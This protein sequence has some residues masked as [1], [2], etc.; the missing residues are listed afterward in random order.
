MSGQISR[1]VRYS[2]LPLAL[3]HLLSLSRFSSLLVWWYG[4]KIV[5][6]F[7]DREQR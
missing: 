5:S 1:R 2:Y 4:A 3:I 7:A 6:R